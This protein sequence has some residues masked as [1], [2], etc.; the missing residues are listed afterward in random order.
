LVAELGLK[1]VTQ[2]PWIMVDDDLKAAFR[3]E[4]L[5]EL[6]DYFVPHARRDVQHVYDAFG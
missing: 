5:K 6:E 2:R 3:H 1:L 4:R